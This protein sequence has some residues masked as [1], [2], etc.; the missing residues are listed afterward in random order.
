MQISTVLLLIV[1]CIASA[2][3]QVSLPDLPL[4]FQAK[5]TLTLPFIGASPGVMYYDYLNSRVRYDTNSMFGTA[6]SIQRWDIETPTEYDIYGNECQ[7]KLLNGTMN[8]MSIPPFA[9]YQ[10]SDYVNNVECDHWNV[11]FFG[12]GMDWWVSNSTDGDGKVS[13]QMVRF[14]ENAI[15]STIDFG[16]TVAGPVDYSFFDIS[17][18]GCPS[19]I[20]P[21]TYT[22]A[23][24][25]KNAIN[26][27]VIPGATVLVNGISVPTDANGKYEFTGLQAGTYLVNASANGFYTS[28]QSIVIVSDNIPA[29][30]SGDFSLSPVLNP[31]QFRAILT[32]GASP[33]DLDAHLKT[34]S[35]SVYYG[36]RSCNGATLDVDQRYGFGPETITIANTPTGTY[37]YYVVNYSGEQPLTVSNGR[38]QVFGNGGLVADIRVPTD[39]SSSSYR[40]WMGFS[41]DQ[42]GAVTVLNKLVSSYSL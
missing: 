3:A 13:Y 18:Y 33:R 26:N 8:S 27:K 6:I 36:Y 2:A 19:P 40:Y 35:C 24:Y 4:Q 38:I 32:W 16:A 39:A 15:G 31:G 34:P 20:P 5:V 41:V 23:G 12:I 22:L 29:G 30:T 1:A 14:S 11:D 21:V 7:S 25:V 42:T 9:T 28:Q 10:G 37:T 17:S